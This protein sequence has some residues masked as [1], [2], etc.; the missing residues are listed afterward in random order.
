[1]KKNYN[2]IGAILDRSGSMQ[3][4]KIQEARVGFNTFIEEQ[5]NKK[6]KETDVYVTIFDN[7]IDTLYQG[8]INSCPELNENNFFARSMTSLYDAIGH[9]IKNVGEILKNKQ[10]DMRP[11]KVMLI[12]I[13]DGMENNSSEYISE[14]IKSM[15]EEQRD[16][17]SWEIIFMGA[18][19][20][21][22]LQSQSIGIDLSHTLS[23]SDTADGVTAAYSVMSMAYDSFDSGDFR[24]FSSQ[25][26]EDEVKKY[27]ITNK[28]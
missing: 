2:F 20:D 10:E 25:T 24:G 13:T 22:M 23:Y 15:I 7:E 9:T 1:M 5:K 28:K 12:I 11:E 14:N 17:Y 8:D 4:D 16:K 21:V 3:G 19:E 26:A 6:E 27:K 18:G